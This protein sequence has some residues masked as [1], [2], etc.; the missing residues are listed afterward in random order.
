MKRFLVVDAASAVVVVAVVILGLNARQ[1]CALVPVRTTHV[2]VRTTSTTTHQTS[3]QHVM[4]PLFGILDDMRAAEKRSDDI[5]VAAHADAVGSSEAV[6]LANHPEFH[7]LYH[8]LIFATD[9]SRQITK[10]LDECT[11][12]EFLD[13]LHSLQQSTNV[14]TERHGLVELID[15]RPNVMQRT[16]PNR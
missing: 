8:D 15:T 9:L 1:S 4:F 10:K 11:H 2:P 12:P 3:F 6:L 13:F 5:P 14:E 7:D 16:R